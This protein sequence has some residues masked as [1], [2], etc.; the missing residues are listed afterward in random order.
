MG[1]KDHLLAS[2]PLFHDVAAGTDGLLPVIFI[3]CVLRHDPHHRHGIRPDRIGLV[4]MKFYGL[5]IDS[6]CLLKHGEIVHRAAV[7]A[8]VIRK[9]NILGSQRFPVCKSNVILDGHCPGKAVLAALIVCG[10]ILFYLQILCGTH[11]GAL[12]QGFMHVLSGSPAIRGIK[13]GG[14]L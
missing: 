8:V 4:H 11:K 3:V 14:R 5:F 6:H 1:L 10:Q 12:D 9:S 13:S 2:V 7:P